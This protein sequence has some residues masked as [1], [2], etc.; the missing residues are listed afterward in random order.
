MHRAFR[1]VMT[2]GANEDSFSEIL[3]TKF[4]QFVNLLNRNSFDTFLFKN[5]SQKEI[6]DGSSSP[7]EN[8]I[9]YDFTECFVSVMDAFKK[10]EIP[11][12]EKSLI[13]QDYAKNISNAYDELISGTYTTGSLEPERTKLS[14]L[15]LPYQ[16]NHS[17]IKYLVDG[18]NLFGFH[19]N[20][21]YDADTNENNDLVNAIRYLRHFIA[22]LKLDRLTGKDV[23]NFLREDMNFRNYVKG[24]CDIFTSNSHYFTEGTDFSSKNKDDKKKIKN[25]LRD[26][27]YHGLAGIATKIIDEFRNI[28]SLTNIKNINYGSFLGVVTYDE[29][30]VDDYH[31]GDK[32][33]EWVKKIIPNIS[34]L[35]LHALY[36]AFTDI[37][38]PRY[39]TA[40]TNINNTGMTEDEINEM[41]TN[42]LYN[43]IYVKFGRKNI[44]KEKYKLLN[45][46]IGG[47]NPRRATAAEVMAD[48]PTKAYVS[49]PFLYG[50]EY[51]DHKYYL[52]T[53]KKRGNSNNAII[54]YSESIDYIY[55]DENRGIIPEITVISNSP[56]DN[57]ERIILL[58]IVTF[59]INSNK[60]TD[61]EGF[62]PFINIDEDDQKKIIK[63][64]KEAFEGYKKLGSILK[65]LSNDT[66]PKYFAKYRDHFVNDFVLHSSSY[67]EWDNTNKSINVRNQELKYTKQT[68]NTLAMPKI[69][70]FFFDVVINDENFYRDFFNLMRTEPGKD[71]EPVDDDVGFNAVKDIENN[72]DELKKYRLN[73]K[74]VSGFSVLRGGCRMNGG[75]NFGDI[76]L[77]S[78]IP[79]YPMDDSVEGIW[80]TRRDY[81]NAKTLKNVGTD[82][83]RRIGRNVY[84]RKSGTDE[85]KIYEHTINVKAMTNASL[86]R[87]YF[88]IDY[89]KLFKESLKDADPHGMKP[90]GTWENMNIHLTENALREA[91]RWQRVHD[92]NDENYGNF[93]YIVN[94]KVED[95]KDDENCSFIGRSVNECLDVLSS[96]ANSTIEDGKVASVCQNIMDFDFKINVPMNDVAN[97]ISKMN[98]RLAYKILRQF[99][100]CSY[101]SDSE[102]VPFKGIRRYKVQSVADWLREMGASGQRCSES[103]AII[104]RPCNPKSLREQLG[105]DMANRIIKYARQVDKSAFFDYLQILVSWVNANFQVLNPEE[106]TDFKHNE[107]W[108]KNDDRYAIYDYLNP[109]RS[110]INIRMK[111]LS[112]GLERLKS[113]IVNDTAG[114][115]GADLMSVIASTPIGIEMPLARPGFTYAIPSADFGVFYGGSS[116]VEESMK[117]ISKQYGYE[118]FANIYDYLKSSMNELKT[119]MK[120][121]STTDQNISKKLETFKNAEEELRKSLLNL[122]ERNQLYRASQGFINTYDMDDDNFKK[123]LEKHSNLLNISSAY[124]RK[125][126]N[127]IDLFQ[128]IA[129]AITDKVENGQSSKSYS[130]RTHTRPL[131]PTYYSS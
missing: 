116:G 53:K 67:F 108:P 107:S 5:L 40:M 43:P 66:D 15:Q 46:Q 65:E 25:F 79:I 44:D 64:I 20:V 45:K 12:I 104:E 73:V 92:A 36:K 61:D 54:V 42:A 88:P 121:K 10:I 28:P 30:A 21:Y 37:Q 124:N 131:S 97:K 63:Q 119:K 103:V 126:R 112:C 24:I 91:S 55:K 11:I 113:S 13:T 49:L 71:G 51:S 100:F 127:L 35:N 59:I 111:S 32:F 128:T 125:A 1:N 52:V 9:H 99:K 120:L 87:T 56:N 6:S 17:K 74:K 72:N 60:S 109:Y 130:N 76:V 29:H 39:S 27:I 98:P 114:A 26:G 81:V 84:F 23:I 77:L 22:L 89:H 8:D 80:L 70:K 16:H 86:L 41:I 118:L 101:L 93:V 3:G 117:N 68:S 123:V 31:R 115:R 110:K 34:N 95:I 102:T 78:L 7:K 14:F 2:G 38:S 69:K 105:E 75:E 85:I 19:D 4:K 94:D 106:F 83:I 96:C 47:V 33:N 82:A 90:S 62:Y 122:I 48:D 18:F 50:P 57:L 58:Q 129:K